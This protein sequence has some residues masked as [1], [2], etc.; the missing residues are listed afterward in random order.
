RTDGLNDSCSIGIGLHDCQR[1]E[2]SERRMIRLR[3]VHLVL[4]L[5]GQTLR[6]NLK[7]IHQAERIY[8]H[9]CLCIGQCGSSCLQVQTCSI[10]GFTKWRERFSAPDPFGT[11]FG[12][13]TRACVVCP[14]GMLAITL[15]LTVSIAAAMLPFSRATYT[16]EPSPD[17]QIPCGRLPTGIVATSSGFGPLRNA[18]TSFAP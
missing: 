9:R 2:F 8:G 5:R 6:S 11:A 1:F 16:L 14:I 17:G 3:E 13:Y 10:G 7:K 4:R 12:T 18:F 15:L